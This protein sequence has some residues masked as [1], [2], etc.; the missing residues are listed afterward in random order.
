MEF[1]LEPVKVDL[2]I[3]TPSLGRDAFYSLCFI[4]ENDEAP[5][6]L[7]VERL[8]DLLDNGYDRLSLA[9]NFCVGVFA[10]QG[11]DTVYIRAKRL[12]ESY[13]DAFSADDNS[14]FYFV[15]IES[16]ELYEISKFN[17]YLIGEDEFK[18]QFYS[19]NSK[20]LFEA[21]NGKLV[22]YYQ[23][24]FDFSEE[25]NYYL[26]KAYRVT[27][28]HKYAS[29][30]YPI[31]VDEDAY[32]ASIEVL[33]AGMKILG[34]NL[35]ESYQASIQVLDSELKVVIRDYVLEIGNDG[36]QASIEVLNSEL[37]SINRYY[38]LQVAT[39]SY[40]ASIEVLNSEL[41]D[42]R[43]YITYSAGGEAYTASITVLDSTLKI[44]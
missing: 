41:K 40:Q 18:L 38:E 13:E 3:E 22:N 36:Y 12:S 7:K 10:Q 11:M 17:E 6:T 1:N 24:V 42:V 2:Q 4:T 33:D 26:N 35:V 39:D 8:R 9:Y 21:H 5:R 20:D 15:V 30:P 14:D 44:I 16:K 29:H 25:E 19:N 34:L 37:K 32:T 43:R 23:E 27:T 31:L 28:T